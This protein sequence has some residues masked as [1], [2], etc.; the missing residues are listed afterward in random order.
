MAAFI[1]RKMFK[2]CEH[3]LSNTDSF[4]QGNLIT[5]YRW[6]I[7]LD[8]WLSNYGLYHNWAL[9]LLWPQNIE[10]TF[11]KN[12][13]MP[14]QAA[15]VSGASG[16]WQEPSGFWTPG[17]SDVWC[18]MWTGLDTWDWSQARPANSALTG[19]LWWWRS[20]KRL[21]DRDNQMCICFSSTLYLLI[22]HALA[23]TSA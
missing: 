4:M 7:G 10:C 6:R 19:K 9:S 8:T 14:A 17:G 1:K 12:I 13:V 16:H 20:L 5:L 3:F 22:M 2:M 11:V 23:K 18:V 15:R 21:I